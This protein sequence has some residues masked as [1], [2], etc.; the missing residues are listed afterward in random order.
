MAIGLK[1]FIMGKSNACETAADDMLNDIATLKTVP[2]ESI[3]MARENVWS[4]IGEFEAALQQVARLPEQ[5]RLMMT[6]VENAVSGMN[7]L[8]NRLENSETALAE[9]VQ[10]SGELMQ[11]R[12]NLAQELTQTLSALKL[13]E[14]T[15][16]ALKL[17]NATIEASHLQLGQDH[18]ALQ[19]LLGQMEPQIHELTTLR[20]ALQ[21]EV[22]DLRLAKDIADK[23]IDELHSELQ[24]AIDTISDR[25]HVLSNLQ[26][27]HERLRER[28][29]SAGKSISELECAVVQ[30]EEKYNAGKLELNRERKTSASLRIENLQLRKDAEEARMQSESEIETLQSRHQFLD[31][32]M[33][34]SRARL[35]EESRQL[36]QARLERVDRD[37]EIGRLKLALEASQR[38]SNE[39]RAQLQAAS[40]SASTTGQL[41]SGEIDTRHRLELELD[42]L[43]NENSALTIKNKGLTEGARM[44]DMAHAD[45]IQKLQARLAKLSA[46]NDQLR[47]VVRVANDHN[48]SLVAKMA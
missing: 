16:A 11:E 19:H 17:Q 35:G 10:R 46:E 12:A 2:T 47:S 3:N 37:R 33:A 22:E 34:D 8:R 20:N 5:F 25:N 29:D 32:A 40:T 21:G 48:E 27:T 41:L 7:L 14:A 15:A 42:M 44:A 4:H 39:L 38:E 13:E 43:R 36:S 6:P 18:A 30:L 31:Q 23:T 9:E 45:A 26:L 28:L 1:K 24:N